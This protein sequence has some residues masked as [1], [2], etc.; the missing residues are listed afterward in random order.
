VTDAQVTALT[1]LVRTINRRRPHITQERIRAMTDE[2]H[3]ILVAEASDGSLIG[4]ATLIYYHQLDCGRVATIETLAVHEV[5]RKQGIG[6][7]L[8][9][10][11]LAIASQ[12]GVSGAHLTCNPEHTNALRVYER[13]GFK[14]RSANVYALDMHPPS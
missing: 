2:G 6:E 3:V 12:G 1:V 7:A 8:L 9:T 10:R 4:V 13:L 14:Q 11:L 5:Y